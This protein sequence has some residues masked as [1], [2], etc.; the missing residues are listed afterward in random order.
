MLIDLNES[1][2]HA[3]LRIRQNLM[4]METVLAGLSCDNPN[5]RLIESLVE[6]LRAKEARLSGPQQQR[7]N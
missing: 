3:L 7:V 6:R 2:R 4:E 1:R 5:R